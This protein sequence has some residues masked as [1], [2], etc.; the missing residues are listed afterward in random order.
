MPIRTG[1]LEGMKCCGNTPLDSSHDGNPQEA[2]M[3]DRVLGAASSPP[4]AHAA[5][6]SSEQ[7]SANVSDILA[8]LRTMNSH[9]SVIA[10]ALTQL[11]SSLAPQQDTH[12]T[13]PP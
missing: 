9:L 10:R 13:P 6:P 4:A 3:G 11:A 8:E 12:G 5:P 2:P 7:S 1:S